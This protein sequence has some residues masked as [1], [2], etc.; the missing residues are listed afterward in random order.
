MKLSLELQ[1]QPTDFLLL[2]ALQDAHSIL[3]K[4]R[5]KCAS[6]PM[7]PWTM[8]IHAQERIQREMNELVAPIFVDPRFEH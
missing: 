4:A 2:E 6:G 1:Q 7:Q 5:S 8:L 3:A